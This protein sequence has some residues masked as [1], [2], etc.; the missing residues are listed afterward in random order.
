MDLVT[1]KK[2][3]LEY[4]IVEEFTAG[5]ELIGL[6]VK[7]IRKGHAQ[8]DGSHI[9]IRGGEAFLLQSKINP[10]QPANTPASYEPIHPRRLLLKKKELINL[11]ASEQQKGL[12]LI[13]LTLYNSGNRI[14]LRFAVVKKKKLHDKR[15]ALKKRETERSM[16]RS[17]TTGYGDD[18]S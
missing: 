7:S 6:E 1:N 15:E 3:W 11:A 13:P 9:A 18:R 2:A 4:Q 10:Y 17:M 14:K 8:L 5:I 12:T 16:R